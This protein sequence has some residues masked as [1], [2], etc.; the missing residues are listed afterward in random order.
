M[1]LI[2]RRAEGCAASERI[3]ITSRRSAGHRNLPLTRR[4]NCKDI[5]ASLRRSSVGSRRGNEPIQY[6]AC[7][8]STAAQEDFN[9][10]CWWWWRKQRPYFYRE[11]KRSSSSQ[12]DN[13]RK[14][15]FGI[16]HETRCKAIKA[17]DGR[18]CE[19]P[20]WEAPC[21]PANAGTTASSLWTFRLTLYENEHIMFNVSFK[22]LHKYV[23]HLVDL[24]ALIA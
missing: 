4:S 3:S 20:F 22:L 8:I 19:E 24:Q 17:R 11:R 23:H 16:M 14:R 9:K 1:P 18:K 2:A 13:N 5:H 6:Q 15:V 7:C 12:R 10:C 21:S